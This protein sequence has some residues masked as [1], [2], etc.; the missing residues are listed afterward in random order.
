ME[1]KPSSFRIFDASAGSGKTFTLTLEYLTQLLKPGSRQAFREMLAIT[2]TNK[3][4]AELKHRILR[5]LELLAEASEATR[6]APFLSALSLRLGAGPEEIGSRA[7]KALAELLH[8]YAF[9]DISTIDK[10]NHRIL[11]TFARDLDL[12][13]N[14]EVVLDASS[15][16]QRAVE[17]LLMKTGQDP[18]LTAVLIEFALEKTAED[19]SWDIGRDLMDLSDLLF[20]ENEYHYLHAFQG[21]QM[22]DFLALRK[23]LESKVE[24]STK[25]ILE[26]VANMQDLIRQNGL[27]TSDFHAGYFPKFLTKIREGHLE[28]DFTAGWKQDFG[29]KSLWVA[30]TPQD[31]KDRMDALLPVFAGHFQK[32]RALM[33]ERA[34]LTNAR[35][36]IAPFTVLGL[37]QREL[38]S[39]QRDESLLPIAHFNAIIA[40]ELAEQP[41]PYIYE[42]LGEKYRHY[43]IDEFQDTSR[44]QWTN[45]VPLI[46]NAL[47]GQDEAGNTGSL[48]LVGDAKQAIYRWRGGHAE[49]FIGLVAGPGNPFSVA[50]EVSELPVNYRSRQ[51]VI[52]FNNEFFSFASGF[53]SRDAYGELFSKGNRQESKS[54]EEGLVCLRFIDPDA[55]DADAEYAAS[56][57]QAIRELLAAGY[58]YGD[59]CILTRRR[60]EGIYLA[61]V[62]ADAG[63][64]VISSETLLLSTHPD[65]RFLINL[66]RYLL[67]P[68]DR[69]HRY[70]I[71][72]FLLPA[73]TRMHSEVE[74]HLKTTEGYLE[75]QWGFHTAAAA[76]MP[77]YDILE[78]AIRQ[79]GLAGASDA[80]LTFLLDEALE[81]G[82]RTDPSIAAFLE[83]WETKSEQLSITVP[84]E[85][86]AVRLMTIHKAKGLEFPAVIFPFADAKIYGEHPSRLWVPVDPEEFEGFS[87]VQISSKQEVEAYG[88]DAATLYRAEREKLELDAFNV[89]YVA[90]TRSAEALYVISK[91]AGRKGSGTPQSYSDLYI[92]FLE[93]EGR[94][95]PAVREYRYGSL[96]PKPATGESLGRE[97]IPFTYTD[98]DRQLLRVVTR[99]GERWGTAQEAAIQYGNILHYALSLVRTASDTNSAVARLIGEGLLPAQDRGLFLGLLNDIVGHPGLAPYFES[100]LLVYNER[101]LISENGLLLRPDRLVIRKDAAVVIDYK[102]GAAKAG[103]REQ[104]SAYTR[105][106]RALGYHPVE[107]ILVYIAENGIQITTL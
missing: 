24:L 31:K 72:T 55:G 36:N 99:S 5:N 78:T 28:P 94:W 52:R 79:F 12:P 75:R 71:L 74:Q 22:H 76:L 44:L 33:Y 59:I 16:L 19:R 38:E 41:A 87:F 25:Q 64:Q 26:E 32:M 98:K 27:E 35:K 60:K 8:N 13:A 58:D 7:R 101:D 77:A 37:L 85:Y 104:L 68:F 17:N 20:N 69:N 9:F 81:V 14:F 62:L 54:E 46:A 11:R 45:L 39:L 66:L 82:L 6:S 51:T 90:H 88:E 80:Y 73:G 23:R 97:T 67:E 21:K 10:F 1:E 3:A 43:F 56:T 4:V 42:R 29:T 100:G 103:H 89:L 70:E 2:F 106:V 30:R 47:E 91:N 48:V 63:I 34:F 57:L 93:R 83:H 65:I 96:S 84:E 40:E 105:T 50:A 15:L 95:D 18:E 86:N 61:G 92:R 53:L 49:Q 107:A 102:T